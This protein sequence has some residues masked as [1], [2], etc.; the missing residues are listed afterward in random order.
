MLDDPRVGV[1]GVFLSR[2]EACDESDIDQAVV[3][4]GSIEAC[5]KAAPYVLPVTSVSDLA[6]SE[7]SCKNGPRNAITQPEGQ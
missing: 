2:R 4:G 7:V 5:R 1:C 6:E 3:T